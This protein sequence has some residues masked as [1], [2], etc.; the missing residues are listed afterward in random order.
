MAKDLPNL[1]KQSLQVK[2]ALKKLAARQLPRILTQICRDPNNSAYGCADRNWWHYKIRDFPSIILQQAALSIHFAER[3]NING[4]SKLDNLAKASAKFWNKRIKKHGSFEEYY[5]W[6]QGYPPLAFST[7]AI[8]L[9]VKNEVLI[10]GLVS[11]GARIAASQLIRRFESQAANQQI[12]GL[13]ALAWIKKIYPELVNKEKFEKLSERS[14]SLQNNE[15]WFEEYGGPDLGY[16]SVTLDCLWDLYDATGEEKYF[17]SAKKGFEFLAS[18][19]SF[20]GGN[21]GMHNSRNTD[22]IVPYGISRFLACDGI[23]STKAG[24]TLNELYSSADKNRHF[25]SSVDDRYWC[26]Y[27]GVSLYRSI[28]ILPDSLP[29]VSAKK[30]SENFICFKNSGHIVIKMNNGY[31]LVS[32]N[33]GGILNLYKGTREIADY[34]WIIRKNK[35]QWVNHFWSDLWDSEYIE[36]SDCILVKIEGPFFPHKEIKSDP[37]IHLGLRALSFIMGRHLIKFLKSKLIFKNRLSSSKLVRKIKIFSN[38]I[39]GLLCI[40]RF[41]SN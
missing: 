12:A 38:N 39:Y 25:F 23:L 28:N 24:N 8:M 11:D 17:V 26:H 6:E 21:I 35:K 13:A 41:G 18:M 2:H 36:K 9:M 5:P 15:G 22:Y 10:P 1:E 29:Y 7:L 4:R 27:I 40:Q 19:V 34:G 16:L 33:K 14:L 3:L 31:V 30:R 32:T 20:A 37:F